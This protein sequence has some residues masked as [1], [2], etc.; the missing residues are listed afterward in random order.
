VEREL[1]V[2]VIKWEHADIAE[3]VRRILCRLADV[4][5]EL[6]PERS[7]CVY[8]SIEALRNQPSTRGIIDP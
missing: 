3:D 6:E 2:I 1:S 4:W 7:Y 8:N 5:R